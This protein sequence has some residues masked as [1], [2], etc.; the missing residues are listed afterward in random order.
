LSD[1]RRMP[2]QPATHHA[3]IHHL[4]INAKPAWLLKS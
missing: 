1:P 4:P 3:F 2:S